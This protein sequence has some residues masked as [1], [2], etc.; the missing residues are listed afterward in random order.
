M[1][2]KKTNLNIENYLIINNNEIYIQ[3]LCMHV[4]TNF[5]DNMKGSAT[6]C[7]FKYQRTIKII[8]TQYHLVINY[9]MRINH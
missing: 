7:Y 2:N 6:M 3:T 9:W 8:V 1:S 4:S 5:C